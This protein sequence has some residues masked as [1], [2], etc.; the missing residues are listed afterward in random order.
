MGIKKTFLGMAASVGLS[1][2]AGMGNAQAGQNGVDEADLNLNSNTDFAPTMTVDG[3]AGGGLDQSSQIAGDAFDM[4]TK[5]EAYKNQKNAEIDKKITPSL[6][7]LSIQHGEEVGCFTVE[8]DMDGNDYAKFNTSYG[9]Q[10]ESQEYIMDQCLQNVAWHATQDDL[11]H[12]SMEGEAIAQ[13]VSL[14]DFMVNLTDN[15]KEKHALNALAGEAFGKNINPDI[16]PLGFDHPT[17]TQSAENVSVQFDG[18]TEYDDIASKKDQILAQTA[19]KVDDSLG[20]LV[21]EDISPSE[22]IALTEE[23]YGTV[24]NNWD[25]EGTQYSVGIVEQAAQAMDFEQK[26]LDN[27]L[28]QERSEIGLSP[29]KSEVPDIEPVEPEK[30]E[31]EIANMI[32]K[33]DGFDR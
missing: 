3:G 20:K 18:L 12:L 5:A 16:E 19:E 28:D 24:A 31:S 30:V 25:K 13:N 15:L 8:Q 6:E 29:Y 27:S 23:L 4:F 2:G 14:D 33:D 26:A 11:D 10:N 1:M 7:Y 22:R 9:N 32:D 17:Y 21:S